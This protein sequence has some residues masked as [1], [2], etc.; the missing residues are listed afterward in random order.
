MCF[1]NGGKF[2]NKKETRKI[3]IKYVDLRGKELDL[4]SHGED[5]DVDLCSVDLAEDWEQQAGVGR[6]SPSN[7]GLLEA[8]SSSSSP[9][10]RP[11][12]V[13][14]YPQAV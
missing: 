4:D 13:Q 1:V 12:C 8:T 5:L 2:I 10:A 6:Y 14:Q 11:A 7:P 9:K 3:K